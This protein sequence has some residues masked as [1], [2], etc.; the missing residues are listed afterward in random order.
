[1]KLTLE[2][3]VTAGMATFAEQGYQGLSMRQVADRLDVHAGSLYYH[4][5]NKEALLALLADRVAVEAYDAGTA[6][7]AALP[8]GAGWQ[9][10]IEAQS[11]ALRHSIR[12]RRGGPVLLAGSPTTLSAGA[13]GLMERLLSTMAAA[14]L[15][16]E[17]RGPAADV[18]LSHIT[19][20]VLQEQNE[21]N[22]PAVTAEQVAE[23]GRRFPLTMATGPELDADEVF[24]RSVHLICAGIATL[25]P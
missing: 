13:L 10:R 6:A 17:H 23:L 20:F 4:V 19:G 9:Q 25:I 21:G 18:L 11:L 15:P 22:T 24:R 14:G 1:M 16:A 12:A 5:R 3:I 2:R 7:L 8:A